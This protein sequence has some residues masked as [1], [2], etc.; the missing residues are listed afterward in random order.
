MDIVS[1]VQPLGEN[2]SDDVVEAEDVVLNENSLKPTRPTSL[3]LKQKL[4]LQR[5][6]STPPHERINRK[7]LL[8]MYISRSKRN[9]SLQRQSW[10]PVAIGSFT[11]QRNHRFNVNDRRSMYIMPGG[12][13]SVIMEEDTMLNLETC[14]S[15]GSNLTLHS[16]GIPSFSAHLLHA[17]FPRKT[18]SSS[19]ASVASSS[20]FDLEMGQMNGNVSFGYEFLYVVR[21]TN[22]PNDG[23]IWGWVYIHVFMICPTSFFSNLET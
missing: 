4:E 11:P 2:F 9:H 22:S 20:I 5:S 1:L 15:H 8:E 21:N 12:R 19:I 14:S 6:L 3:L 23:V 10:H 17:V 13:D 18:R 7:Q 16:V